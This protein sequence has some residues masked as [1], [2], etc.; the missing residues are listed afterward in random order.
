MTITNKQLNEYRTQASEIKAML[1]SIRRNIV[2]RDHQFYFLGA[3]ASVYGRVFKLF[4]NLIRNGYVFESIVQPPQY[5]GSAGNFM[6][7]RSACF[8]LERRCNELVHIEEGNYKHFARLIADL[9]TQFYS[10]LTIP[11]NKSL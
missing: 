8:D 3:S 11:K 9:A 4:Y 1:K 10:V 7:L 2:K 5:N 6:N